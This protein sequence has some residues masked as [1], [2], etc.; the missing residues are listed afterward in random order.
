[1]SVRQI[2]VCHKRGESADEIL[3]N[4]PQLSLAKVYAALAYYYANQE[5]ME[6]EL[7]AEAAEYERL[8]AEDRARKAA[9]V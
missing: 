8:A 9:K 4:Y 7:A 1:V 3:E 2:A 6:A 5:E